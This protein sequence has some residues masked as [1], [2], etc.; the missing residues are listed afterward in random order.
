MNRS[1]VTGDLASHGNIF[2][3]IANDRVG[4]G[5]TIPTD[6]LDLKGDLKLE[7]SWG[8]GNHIKFH[9]SNNTLNLPSASLSN[10]ARLPK[11]SFGD[12][13]SD[14]QLGVGDFRMYHDYYNMHMRYVGANGNLVIGNQSTAIQINGSN[15]SG[16]PQSSIYIPAG[17]TEGVKLYQANTLRFE[18]VG[19]GVTVHGTTETQELNVTGV[20]TFSALSKFNED[21]YFLGASSKTITFDQSEGHIRYLDNAKAQFGTQGDLSIYHSGSASYITD[22]G[23]GNLLIQ[24]NNLVLENTS[25]TNYMV[26]VSG[27]EVV[28]YHNGNSKLT[29]TAYG[30]DVT[31]TTGTDGLVVSGVSTFSSVIDANAGADISGGVSIGGEL[32]LIGSSDAAK[33]IDA[34]VGT[35]NNLNFRSTSGGDSNH[36]TMMSLNTSGASITGDLTVGDGTADSAAGPEFKLNRNS[37]SP[38]NAD[39]LGQIKFAGRSST[40]V[41]RNYA[42]ITGKILDVTNGSEDGILEFAHIKAGSQVITGRWRSDSL[43]LLNSTNLSVN[44]TSMFESDVTI[45]CTGDANLN[46]V[47]DTGNNNESSVP[48]INFTQDG[49]VNIF[50]VGV[51]GTAGETFTGSTSNT[52]YLI[53][54]TGHGGMSL[55]FGTNNALR[56]KLTTSALQPAANATYDLG[57]SSLKWREIYT[58]NF[59]TTATGFE[60]VGTQFKFSDTADTNVIIN[61]DTDNNDE[62]HHPSLSFKQDG[63]VHVLDIGVN[64][65]TSDYTGATHNFGYVRIG[66]HNNVGLE[67]ATG[68]SSQTKRLTIDHNGHIIP[69]A[70][71]TYNIGSNSVRFANVYADTLYGDGSNL[72][73]AVATRVTVTDNSSDTSCFVL[74]TQGATGNQLPHSGSNLT[75][76]ASSG[77][78]TATS[79]SGNGASLTNV[80]ATTLDSIDSG[81]FLRSDANDSASGKISFSGG[82]SAIG[83][84]ANSDIR[85]ASGNWTG[86]SM[87][88]QGH[89]NRLY[90]QGGSDGIHLRGSDGGDIARFTNTA[91][92]FYDPVTVSGDAT[93]NGG[94]SAVSI[95]AGSDIR[96]ASGAWTGNAYGKI[97]HHSDRLYI[98]GGSAA[99]YMIVFRGNSSTDRVY[100]R[101]NG[102][103]YPAADSNSDL[104]KSG[105]RWAN[106]YADTLYGD[107]SNLTGIVGVTINNNANDRVATCTGTTGTLNGEANLQFNG[108]R[109]LVQHGTNSAVTCALRLSNP[110]EGSGSGT[111]IEFHNG[112]GSNTGAGVMGRIKTVDVGSYDA[113]MR[114]EVSNKG[115][116]STATIEAARLNKDRNL[117]VQGTIT[118]GD[119]TGQPFFKNKTAITTNTTI[120]TTYNW[121]SAG[122]ITINSGVTVTVNSGAT[123]TVV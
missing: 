102:T 33:Y 123:W 23:T 43:Q 87:K 81:S 20:S 73:N 1:R 3:D 16:S 94:A 103:I 55:D 44:G 98:A 37:A 122:P 86:E 84:S 77:L 24:A 80:N 113:D 85:F 6:K 35:S 69:G 13:T 99:E 105:T 17:A 74:F 14:S 93:F 9:H 116:T 31:G 119:G 120:D 89:S 97:Q 29:T 63:T 79:F 45:Q 60:A 65:T 19:Y 10:I 47:A 58:E 18:T 11:I 68:N 117:V 25:G 39:Y 76:N 54:T 22:S 121:M 62:A 26:G 61:A 112:N 53:T 95:G 75:F 92:T 108:S 78:L 106:V 15:G 115:S 71:S 4:I 64:G 28:L 66:G 100:V 49:G 96:L 82:D 72:T 12:R 8:Y 110:G 7:D 46:L 48:T 34:R 50:K 36:V 114:F 27:A 52:P 109:L 40:G 101:E 42:T 57:T 56:M 104:G 107:G 32:N 91:T 70:D 118:A 59:S 88:I 111:E 83:I 51:E 30:I 38:A 2:V 21:V 90:I 41:E 67:I 5:T